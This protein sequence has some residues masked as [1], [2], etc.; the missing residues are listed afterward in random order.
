MQL[1]LSRWNDED[2]ETAGYWL[3]RQLPGFCVER[4]SEGWKIFCGDNYIRRQGPASDRI[5]GEEW[6]PSYALYATV[7][8]QVLGP[9]RTRAAALARLERHLARYLPDRSAL[10]EVL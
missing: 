9:H 2:G 8:Q 6:E 4:S 5:W 7:P 3:I 10:T 1:S